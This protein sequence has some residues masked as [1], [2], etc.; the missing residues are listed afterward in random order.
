MLGHHDVE[1][2]QIVFSVTFQEFHRVRAVEG[3]VY[4]ETGSL[5]KRGEN[6]SDV[7]LVVRDQDAA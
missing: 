3:F 1:K 2:S 7:G 4:D 5:Q 6:P